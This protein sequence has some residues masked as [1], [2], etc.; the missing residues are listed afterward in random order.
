MLVI[1][2]QSHRYDSRLHLF[3]IF[4]MA[5]TVSAADLASNHWLRPLSLSSATSIPNTRSQMS[6]QKM[7]YHLLVHARKCSPDHDPAGRVRWPHTTRP[8]TIELMKQESRTEGV[9]CTWRGEGVL[10]L[11]EN[12][13]EIS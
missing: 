13:V 11:Y 1:P 8:Y 12:V 9:A 4:R 10:T 2:A 5:K 6:F 7:S 3:M